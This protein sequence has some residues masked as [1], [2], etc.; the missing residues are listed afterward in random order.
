MKTPLLILLALT[1]TACTNAA[2][3][4]VAASADHSAAAAS[5]GSAAAVDSA[6]A[7]VAVPLLVA[8]SAMVVSGAAVAEIQHTPVPTVAPNGPPALR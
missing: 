5:H 2:S 4:H 7:V 1:T 8:G 6:V 3:T